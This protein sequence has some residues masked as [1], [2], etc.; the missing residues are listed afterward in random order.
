VFEVCR[1]YKF[2]AA[3][4]LPWHQGKCNQLHGHTFT[5][6]IWITGKL[7]K[8]EVVM[9]FEHIDEIVEPYIKLLDH[10]YLNKAISNPT[11]E[12]IAIWFWEKLKDKLPLSK[13]VVSE[14]ARG[15]VVYYGEIYYG[16]EKEVVM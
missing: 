8:N 14:S 5:V 7:N 12:N 15:K 13:I 2:S 3:H 9:E 11:C 1:I 10:F 4:Q 16:E 6:E